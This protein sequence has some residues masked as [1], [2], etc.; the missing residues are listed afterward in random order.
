MRKTT[1]QRL[2][3]KDMPTLRRWKKKMKIK[4]IAELVHKWTK[5]VELKVQEENYKK[6]TSRDNYPRPLI[7]CKISK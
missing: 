4:T 3:K 5:W 7:N 1:S 6:L 2:Y